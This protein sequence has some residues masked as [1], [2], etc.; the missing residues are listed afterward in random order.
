MPEEPAD[1]LSYDPD[2]GVLTIETGGRAIRIEGL[3]SQLQLQL[4]KDGALVARALWLEAGQADVLIKMIEYILEK[5]RIT[6]G[7]AETLRALLPY[8]Q[9]IR[10]RSIPPNGQDGD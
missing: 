10:S 8:L 6:Q 3:A 1:V 4:L 7:S 2:A 9:R 5:V